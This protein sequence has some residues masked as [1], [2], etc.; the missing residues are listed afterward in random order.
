MYRPSGTRTP[1]DTPDHTYACW[2]PVGSPAYHERRA[3][4]DESV[5]AVGAGVDVEQ[6]TFEDV[7]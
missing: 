7:S 6:A 1:A 2:Y 5:V 4:L 3:E